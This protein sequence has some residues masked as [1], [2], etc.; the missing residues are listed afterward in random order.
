[1]RKSKDLHSKPRFS[2]GIPAKS[3]TRRAAELARFLSHE[4]YAEEILQEYY[5]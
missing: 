1:M 4:E 3:T 2:G 5:Q